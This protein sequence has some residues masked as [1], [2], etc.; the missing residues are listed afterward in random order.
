[1]IVII[2]TNIFCIDHMSD[3]MLNVLYLK[4]FLIH[5]SSTVTVADNKSYKHSAI[6]V[7]KWQ[8]EIFHFKQGLT[9]TTSATEALC[10][11]WTSALE[12]I[13]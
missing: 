9:M 4:Y 6:I 3:T 7:R 10:D 8:G 5:L 13:I 2:I 11:V 1:M 12:N